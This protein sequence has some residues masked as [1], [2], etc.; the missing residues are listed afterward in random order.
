MRLATGASVAVA[1]SLIA[2][3][4]FAWFA[5]DSVSILSTLVDSLLDAA[6][7]VINLLA[8]RHALTP[9][10]REHRFGHGKAEPLAALGQAAF[11]AG[12]ASLILFEAGHRLYQPVTISNSAVGIAVMVFSIVITAVLV[13]FQHYVVR[14]TGSFAIRADSLHYKGDILVNASVIVSLVLAERL[15]WVQADPLFG[16]AI[17][18]YILMSAWAIAKGA[19]DML[20]D[21]EMPDRDRM[22]IRELALAHPEVRDMHDLRTRL[23]GPNVF[24]QLHL[25]MDGDLRLTRAHEIADQVEAKIVAA[26]PGAEV[27]IHEDPEG[28]DEARRDYT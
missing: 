14:R 28:V 18:V 26:F 11:I 13:G 10:D 24:I 7:S 27:I 15:G 21:R 12:S 16:G 8:V 23:S 2:A 3:K 22:R 5:T 6:A 19:L 25:E 4:L 17:A 1:G 9:A 20:M